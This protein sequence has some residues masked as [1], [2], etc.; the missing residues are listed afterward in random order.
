MDSAKRG[1]RRRRPAGRNFRGPAIANGVARKAKGNRD[2]FRWWLRS[3]QAAERRNRPSAARL[4]Q[5]VR[6]ASTRFLFQQRKRETRYPRGCAAFQ[7]ACHKRDR[8][9]R[10]K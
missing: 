2:A 6:R 8:L 10:K 4:A 3:N 1:T 5:Q 9:L 7:Q